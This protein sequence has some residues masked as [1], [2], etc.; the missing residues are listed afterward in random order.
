MILKSKVPG[1]EGECKPVWLNRNET[2]NR[3]DGGVTGFFK[4]VRRRFGIAWRY[5]EEFHGIIFDGA[6]YSTRYSR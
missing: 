6:V 2:C 3:I 4:L 5:G 1:H